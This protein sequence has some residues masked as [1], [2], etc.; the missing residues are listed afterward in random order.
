MR[1]GSFV[2][3]AV[4]GSL[5]VLVLA[6][7]APAAGKQPSAAES[8][9]GARRLQDFLAKVEQRYRNL[10]PF[11]MQFTQRYTSTTFGSNDEARGTV[12]VV[13]PDRM[14]WVYDVPEGQR[15]ALDG[16]RY[17][18]IDPE[19]QQVKIRELKPGGGD[20]LTE[21]LAG[22]LQL[23]KVF[24]VEPGK[25]KA[26]PGRITLDLVPREPRDD[27]DR[28]VLEADEKDG[29]L[30]RLEVIDPLGNRFEYFFGPPHPAPAPP[31]EAFRLV[32]PPGYTET[33]D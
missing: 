5:A 1:V 10:P 16:H 18:L 22:R 11:E 13:P 21:L 33:R 20:P 14:L 26:P 29:T 8:V 9:A 6:P 4:A 27:M 12:H 15:G 28:A 19:D 2:A 24:M 32:V 25:E 3:R 30:R 23:G 31:A 17:W 7:C